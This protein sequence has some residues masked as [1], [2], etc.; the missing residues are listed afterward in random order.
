M[1]EVVED[2]DKAYLGLVFTTLICRLIFITENTE[3]SVFTAF[4]SAK[5]E[6]QYNNPSYERMTG[7]N[8]VYSTIQDYE[9]IPEG[10]SEL[11]MKLDEPN[12]AADAPEP[13]PPRPHDYLELID[14]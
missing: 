3:F 9:S 4:S 10:Y 13:P 1:Y 14:I 12:T 8:S 2:V 7:V 11:L 6:S 5:S